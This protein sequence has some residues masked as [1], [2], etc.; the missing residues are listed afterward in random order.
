MKFTILH[1]FAFIAFL[2]LATAILLSFIQFDGRTRAIKF[3]DEQ[4]GTVEY[5]TGVSSSFEDWKL[6]SVDL[7]STQIQNRDLIYIRRI[8]P[9]ETIDL[10][11]TRIDDSGLRHLY[12]AKADSIILSGTNVSREGVLDFLEH[13]EGSVGTDT[14]PIN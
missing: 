12:G 11:D 2:S 1:L 13:I 8:D 10:T 3:V 14:A 9:P 6:R 7:S 5:G 4:G